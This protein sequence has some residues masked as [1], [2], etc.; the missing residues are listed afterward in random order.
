MKE[1]CNVTNKSSGRVVYQIKEE[2]LRRV[3][4]PRETKKNIAVSE[5]E[6]LAQQPGGLVIIYNYLQIDDKEVLRYLINGEEAPEYWISE[7]DL[8]NWMNTCSLDAFKDALDFAPE[9]TKDLIKQYAVSMPL[10]D[11]SKRIA[12]KEQLGFDVTTVIENSGDEQ[13]AQPAQKATTRRVAVQEEEAPKRRVV[14]KA[15]ED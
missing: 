9:G 5:L 7:E 13:E 6:K 12:I 10:N 14:V 11:Y 4:Y 1:F 15:S 8:P 2:G 3:F